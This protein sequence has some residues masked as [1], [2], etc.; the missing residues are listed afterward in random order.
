M[1]APNF[2]DRPDSTALRSSETWNFMGNSW[3]EH[4]KSMENHMK[5]RGKA[6]EIHHLTQLM[7]RNMMIRLTLE[8]GESCGRPAFQGLDPLLELRLLHFRQRK[9]GGQQALQTKRYGRLKHTKSMATSLP[10]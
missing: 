7:I 1:G 10:L 6:G 4:G 9:H 2:F 3:E 5:I 8:L